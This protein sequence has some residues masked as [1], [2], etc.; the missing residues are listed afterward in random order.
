MAQLHIRMLL[1]AM[2]LKA[3][4]IHLHSPPFPQA[5]TA[6]LQVMP[7]IWVLLCAMWFITSKA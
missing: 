7:F 5:R 2:R 3:A 4:K 1:H 6:A